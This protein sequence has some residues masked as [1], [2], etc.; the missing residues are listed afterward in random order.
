MGEHHFNLIKAYLWDASALVR[1]YI[2]DGNG[3][4]TANEIFRSLNNS[5]FA[6]EYSKTEV[7][8]ALKRKW[9]HGE[10]ND[11][12]YLRLVWDA[13]DELS[14][15]RVCDVPL[16]E[17]KYMVAALEI[18]KKYRIDIIDA[19]AIVGI[20]NGLLSFF[21]GE[22]GPFLVTADEKMVNAVRDN[23]IEFVNLNKQP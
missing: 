13:H 16:I 15:L 8:T 5:N 18:V 1:L 20:T 10:I 3:T 17:H 4:E 2:K 22:S 19:A 9:N 12:Q 11:D 14:R 6:T 23:N 21:A 7:L